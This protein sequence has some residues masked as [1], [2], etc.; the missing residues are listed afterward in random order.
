MTT[1]ALSSAQK[2]TAY[3]QKMRKNGFRQITAW[4]LDTR[5]E[6]VKEALK[7]ECQAIAQCPDN[8]EWL[9]FAEQNFNEFADD[10]KCE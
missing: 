8:K 5:N 10:W 6:Q 2:M 3:R 9:D 7:R 4:V 1:V